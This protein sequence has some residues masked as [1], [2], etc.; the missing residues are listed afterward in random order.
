M[1]KLGMETTLRYAD[2]FPYFMA[3]A[4]TLNGTKDIPGIYMMAYL[5]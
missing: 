4:K 3:I 5:I 2:V 1:Y